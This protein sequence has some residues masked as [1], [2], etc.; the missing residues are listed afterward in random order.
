VL[1]RGIM[2]MSRRDVPATVRFGR[3]LL[4]PHRQELLADG[5]PV[6]IRSRALDILIVLTAANGGLV[7]KDELLSRVWPSAVVEE[8]TLHFQI[9]ALRKGAG[10]RSRLHQDHFR[11]RLSFDCGHLNT[12]RPRCCLARVTSRSTACD[13]PSTAPVSRR[14]LVSAL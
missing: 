3:F 9:S 4:N 12:R 8:N 1:N 14:L 5:V 7:T 6:R 2:T 13:K 10:P 11:P